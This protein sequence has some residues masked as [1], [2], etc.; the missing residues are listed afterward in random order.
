MYYI[1]L[2]LFQAVIHF[3]IADRSNCV[4]YVSAVLWAIS[5]DRMI[6]H[7]S[8]RLM[9]PLEITHHF[10]WKSIFLRKLCSIGINFSRAMQLFHLLD[11]KN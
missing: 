3:E 2:Q 7:N 11:Y 8:S 9:Q 6:Q 1:G 10:G 4:P 5:I